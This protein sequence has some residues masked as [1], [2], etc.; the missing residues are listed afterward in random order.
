MQRY[1]RTEVNDLINQTQPGEADIARLQN[2]MGGGSRAGSRGSSR[3]GSRANS[4]PPSPGMGMSKS[5][6]VPTLPR[7]VSVSKAAA[8]PSARLN[9]P[10]CK[11]PLSSRRAALPGSAI[12][13]KIPHTAPSPLLRGA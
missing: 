6:S 10:S 11:S 5:A 8:S 2:H 13:D 9:T 1:I 4:R 7:P 3:A 12:L